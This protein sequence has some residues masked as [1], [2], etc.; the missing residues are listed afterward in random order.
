MSFS[1]TP[2]GLILSAYTDDDAK[3]KVIQFVVSPSG[4]SIRIESELGEVIL[5]ASMT[6][7]ND[8]RAV[9]RQ[10]TLTLNQA[11]SEAQERGYF[12]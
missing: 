1:N 9:V 2:N 6:E 7:D 8:L 12:F 10:F 5:D 3:A 11:V 4:Q